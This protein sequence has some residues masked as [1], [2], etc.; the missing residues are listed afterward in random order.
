MSLP[1]LRRTP[2]NACER[3]VYITSQGVAF[4]AYPV[5]G[6]CEIRAKQLQT[7]FFELRAYPDDAAGQDY[8]YPWVPDGVGT[9]QVPKNV[10]DGTIVMTGGLNGCGITVSEEG[11]SYI[12]YHDA[13][14]QYLTPANTR[15]KVVATA[16]PRDYDPLDWGFKAF[17]H[18]LLQ[19]EPSGEVFYGH[20]IVA[21]KKEG[22]FGL[23][24]TGSMKLSGKRTQLPLNVSQ[25]IV[26]F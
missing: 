12:F 16:K 20:C 5:G 21:V 15:G 7:G 10:P 6:R 22:K 1:E 25:C 24:V 3:N 26:T 2:K 17:Q 18:A 11:N 4:P 8:F 9:V 23:Y 13:N 14:C 19:K